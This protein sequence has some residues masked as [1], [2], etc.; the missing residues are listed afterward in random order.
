MTTPVLALRAAIRGACL[1]DPMLAGLMGG[2]VGLYDEPPRGAHPVYAVFGEEIGGP[3]H[4][5]SLGE[6]TARDWSSATERGHEQE[7]SVVV[8]AAPGS[9]AGAIRAADRMADLLDEAPL[10]LVGHRLVHLSLIA[11]EVGR[12]PDSDLAQV[13]LRL[14]AATEV[15]T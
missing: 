8:W 11:F 4:A 6:A 5:L 13:T 12:D 9:A 10:A 1:A 2:A 3:I 15:A 7:A 14:R